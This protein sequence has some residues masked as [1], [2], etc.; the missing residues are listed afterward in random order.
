M[1]IVNAAPKVNIQKD[2]S[3]CYQS[4]VYVSC[5]EKG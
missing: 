1:Y 2:Q 3:A 4:R 5:D